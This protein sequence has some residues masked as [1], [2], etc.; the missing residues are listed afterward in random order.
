MLRIRIRTLILWTLYAAVILALMTPAI[1]AS[2][3]ERRA[4]WLLTALGGPMAMAAFSFLVLKPKP[5]RDWIISFFLGIAST[6]GA[7]ILTILFALLVRDGPATGKLF[8]EVI[9]AICVVGTS[10]FSVFLFKGLIPRRCPSCRKSRL[11]KSLLSGN[12]T[13]TQIPARGDKRALSRDEREAQFESRLFSFYR[14]GA[15]DF[16]TFRSILT[17]QQGCPRCRRS[18]LLRSFRAKDGNMRRWFYYHYA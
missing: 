14:C 1:R 11:L 16:E 9:L 18:T 8:V 13:P 7:S 17:A 4:A 5:S 3:P 12:F 6:V 15:C 2:G 10:R